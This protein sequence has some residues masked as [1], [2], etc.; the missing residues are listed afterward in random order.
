MSEILVEKVLSERVLNM[1]ESATLQMAA[2]ARKMKEQG[3]DVITLSLGEP[4]FDTPQHI[5]DAAVKALADGHT[6]YTAVAG[7]LDLREAICAK[8]KRENG[9]EY[10]PNQIVVSNGAKQDIASLC[11]AMLNEDDEGN[12]F[13]T[14]LGIL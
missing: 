7:N 2:M 9:L 4:D 1:T 11:M 12:Y 10:K 14:I 13:I 5:K 8:L 3:I 6:K